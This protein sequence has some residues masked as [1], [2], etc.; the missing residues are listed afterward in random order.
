MGVGRERCVGMDRKRGVCGQ[1]GRWVW[2]EREMCVGREGGGYG[3]REMGMGR[4]RWVKSSQIKKTLIIPHR[5]IHRV[6][7]EEGVGRKRGGYGQ[8]ERW[9]W[10]QSKVGMGRGR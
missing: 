10:A 3:Q 8:K 6:W 7:A 4:E 5:A 1:R 9:M 2:A